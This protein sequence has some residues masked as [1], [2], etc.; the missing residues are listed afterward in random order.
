MADALLAELIGDGIAGI[1]RRGYRSRQK[2]C[3]VRHVESDAPTSRA[4][5]ARL[6]AFHPMTILHAFTNPISIP[7][8]IDNQAR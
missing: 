5:S 4:H 6:A 3:Q 8:G 7:K 1:K 2:C